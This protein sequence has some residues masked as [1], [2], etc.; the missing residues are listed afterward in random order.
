MTPSLLSRTSK[1]VLLVE[2]K[3]GESA[4]AAK[5]VARLFVDHRW[6]SHGTPAKIISDRDTRFT[7][8]FWEEFTELVGAQTYM[9]TSYHPQT[10]GQAENT[11]KTMETILRAFI[12]PRQKDWDEHLA[13]ADESLQSKIQ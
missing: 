11:N 13:A 3:F 10:D 6:R 4:S 1:L 7:S 9:T 5:Q 2:M 12:E 8:K